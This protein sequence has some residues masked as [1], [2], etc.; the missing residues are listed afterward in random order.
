MIL[1]LHRTKTIVIIA[2]ILF[3]SKTQSNA[4][5]K[6][7]FSTIDRIIKDGIAAKKFPG[8]VV[9]VGHNGRVVFH[10]AYGNRSLIPGP[11]PMT[12]DTIFDVASL[13]K[14]LATAPAVMQLYEQGRILL[15]DPVSKYL[16]AV[17]RQR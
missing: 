6:Q 14:V 12:E 1:A 11:E 16:P 5:Q 7:D 8:A 13:T 3:L 2:A 15:N 17:R 9:I 4:A 10:K